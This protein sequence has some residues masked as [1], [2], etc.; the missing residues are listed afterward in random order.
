MK[1][2]K[3]FFAVSFF[4]FLFSVSS[5]AADK[6]STA[7]NSKQESIV[8]SLLKGINSD[9]Y[10]LRTSSAYLL[11]E[12]KIESAVIPLMKMLHSEENEDARIVAALALYKIG[13]LRG[14]FAVKQAIKY[15]ES[16]RVKKLCSNFYNDFVYKNRLSQINLAIK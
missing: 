2:L 10:G 13:D 5:F 9:N 1:T 15:D 7:T 8:K 11:G 6:C 12:L 3:I 4:I 14:L 16:E